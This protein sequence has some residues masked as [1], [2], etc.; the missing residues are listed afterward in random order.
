MLN[1]NERKKRD[2]AMKNMNIRCQGVMARSFMVN[3][4]A[5]LFVVAQALAQN[6]GPMT[7]PV[8]PPSDSAKPTPSEYS[9]GP[10]DIVGVNIAESAEWSGKYRVS[11]AGD[12]VLPELSEPVHAEGKTAAQLAQDVKKALIDARLFRNPTVNVYVDEFHSRNVTVLGAVSKPGIYA[13][14]KR[15]TVLE[16][17]SMA[18]GLLPTAGNTITLLQSHSVPGTS[19]SPAQP[20]KLNLSKLVAGSDSAFSSEVHE[21]DVL[22]VASAEVVYV[23]GAVVK[24]G[25]FAYPDQSAGMT[26]LQ[27]LAL[28]EGTNSVAAKGRAVL[29]RRSKD[30]SRQDIPVDLG[31]L[32]AGKTEDVF[33]QAND[34]LFV[35][36]SGAKQTLHAAGEI[37][38]AAV[39]GVATYG[40]GYRVGGL[41]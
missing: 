6:P 32:L 38:M 21:G 39:N 16:A 36:T 37:A 40:I 24:P 1:V 5:T 22:T 9:I 18:G 33:M 30:S 31:K 15:T 17:V 27:A 3:F 41:H 23:V 35:P 12:L 19:T 8:T 28:A 20:L 4:L 7:P 14:Q 26:V 25:G 29:V 10:N 13:L 11:E 34:I 2:E